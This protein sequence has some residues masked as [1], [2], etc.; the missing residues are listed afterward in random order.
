MFVFHC[1][2]GEG[3]RERKRGR[4]GKMEG[5][6][7]GEMEGGRERKKEKVGIALFSTLQESVELGVWEEGEGGEGGWEGE[8][9]REEGAVVQSS[10]AVLA[11]HRKEEREK[12]RKLQEALR[13]Y[14]Q[15]CHMTVM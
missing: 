1:S 15:F 7:K 10:R 8:M 12:R 2:V 6:R 9:G 13:L 3:G 14:C 11:A 5:R 4:E